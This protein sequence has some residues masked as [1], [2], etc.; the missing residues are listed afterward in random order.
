MWKLFNILS[1][2]IVCARY[3]RN[4]LSF[5]CG[6]RMMRINGC[7]TNTELQVDINHIKSSE[8]FARLAASGGFYSLHSGRDYIVGRVDVRRPI[9]DKLLTVFLYADLDRGEACPRQNILQL[10]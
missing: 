1:G 8:E 7:R 4:K 2:T 10:N 9:P 6:L 5:P 3:A